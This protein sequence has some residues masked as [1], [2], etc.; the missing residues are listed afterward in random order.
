MK[1]S[2]G[3]LARG[4]PHR[5]PCLTQTVAME[6][7]LPKCQ[8][9]KKLC[10]GVLEMYQRLAHGPQKCRAKA[11]EVYGES[12]INTVVSIVVLNQSKLRTSKGNKS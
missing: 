4:G 10:H 12:E 1:T 6:E 8:A 2:R 3:K 9:Q 11:F 7:H 5:L